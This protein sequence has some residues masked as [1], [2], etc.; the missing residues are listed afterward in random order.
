L[1][2]GV[3]TAIRVAKEFGDKINFV[4]IRLDSGDLAYLSKKAREML[5]EAGFTKAKII[6]SNDLD[7]YTIMNLK[8]QGAEIDA[9]GIGT[10]LI[11]AYDQAALGGVYKLVSIENENGEMVDTIK[12]SANPEK[13]TTPG[14]KRVYR[15]IN[16]GNGHAE[17]DYIALDYENPQ[18]EERLKMFHPVH[19]YISKFVTN[20]A[21][22]ELH[23]DIVVDGSILYKEPTLMEIQAYVEENLHLLWSEYKRTMNPEEY[24]VDLSQACWDNKMKSIKEIKE[25]I[26]K[27]V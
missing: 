9:W 17:G 2:S 4:G 10:K 19:T 5:D 11:T 24:P 14:R 1:R 3:P 7:E 26:T 20:F 23:E 22:K 21:A 18:Q 16:K 6:A 8:S 13:V 12:I 25:K 15:I 27:S